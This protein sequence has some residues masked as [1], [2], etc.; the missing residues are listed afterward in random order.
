[1]FDRLFSTEAA[2]RRQREAPF[3]AERE[4]YLRHRADFGVGQ[5]TLQLRCRELLQIAR[6]LEPNT[7][8]GVS[9]EAI[10][11]AGAGKAASERA[12]IGFDQ[13]GWRERDRSSADLPEVCEFDRQIAQSIAAD[14][15]NSDAASHRESSV[16]SYVAW[17]YG[18]S[19]S[20]WIVNRSPTRSV[21]TSNGV[22]RCA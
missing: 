8:Q 10:R 12:G 1:M 20:P 5:E 19:G 6:L 7:S 9:M 21:E 14:R 15:A 11:R 2:R 17:C 18:N 22:R 3:V 4:C 16:H 13:Q